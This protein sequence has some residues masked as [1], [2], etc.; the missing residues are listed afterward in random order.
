MRSASSSLSFDGALEIYL[1]VIFMGFLRC[2]KTGGEGASG[3]VEF[4]V[5]EIELTHI[6]RLS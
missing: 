4:V 5:C 1:R 6:R 3:S 2:D